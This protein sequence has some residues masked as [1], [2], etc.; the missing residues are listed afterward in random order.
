MVSFARWALLW[1]RGRISCGT[2]THT[3]HQNMVSRELAVSSENHDFSV[4]LSTET[5]LSCCLD[6]W[7]LIH[8]VRTLSY[9]D[10]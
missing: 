5:Q 10:N 3:T 1:A 2:S 7:Y 9:F 4:T 6:R 8:P